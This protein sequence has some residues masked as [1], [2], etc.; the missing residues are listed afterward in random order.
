MLKNWSDWISIPENRFLGGSY[1]NDFINSLDLV[2]N[3]APLLGNSKLPCLFYADDLVLVSETRKGL[4]ES[5]NSLH[6]FTRQ[7]FLE[8]NPKKTKCL[9]FAR[10]KKD[11]HNENLKLGGTILQDCDTYCYLGVLFARSGSM[12]MAAQAL[13]DKALGA[14]FSILRNV[15]K[16]RACDIRILLDIFDKMVLPIALYN[17]EV[18]GTN[19]M[20]TNLKNENFLS[21]QNLSK[22]TVEGLQIKFL[23]MILGLSQ[24][25]SNWAVSGET[26][27]YPIFVK[28]ITSMIKFYFHISQ[29]PS[30]IVK[31]A[32]STSI[33]LSS[34]GFNSWYKYIVRLFKFCNLEHL[35]FTCDYREINYQLSKLKKQLEQKYNEIWGIERAKYQQNS[36]LELFTSLKTEFGFA[37]YLCICKKNLQRIALTKLRVSAHK[38]PIETG[39]YIQTPRIER[40][41][42]IGC[43]EVGDEEHY[44][45]K[46]SHPFIEVVRTPLLEEI[47]SSHPTFRQ[48]STQEKCKYLLSNTDPQTLGTV[49]R[50]C[51][52]IQETFKE[53]VF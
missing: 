21:E 2:N 15:N 13:H 19:F 43:N 5:L 49:G 12:N 52:A 34:E 8:I 26:G 32:L 25:T 40:Q 41:C 53:V 48:L 1:L 35:L 7:W 24:K 37:D 22:H 44:L 46:C 23:K 51:Y 47:A 6:D 3:D 11:R 33:R 10:G 39:R 31:E 30:N 14:M 9:T 38:L 50:L 28:V 17:S 4:Q 36:K 27:R 16:H 45:L 20:P 18:W 29:S 42:P